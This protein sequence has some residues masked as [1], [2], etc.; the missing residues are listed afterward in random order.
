[1]RTKSSISTFVAL[2]LSVFVLSPSCQREV[3]QIETEVVHVEQG[4]SVLSFRLD[5]PG[6]DESTKSVITDPTF[7]SGIK[8]VL[9]L[10]VGSDG[11]WKKAYATT[12]DGLKQL[13]IRADG[14]TSYT[15]YAFANM[16]D[17]TIPTGAG[18][19]IRPDLF[20][21]TLPDSFSGLNST[22]LP[23]AGSIAVPAATV[24]P[25]GVTNI[26]VPLNRLLSK[27][28]V[29]IDK[30]GM[31]FG[32]SDGSALA[33]GSLKVCQVAKVVRP[34]AATANRRAQSSS[35]VYS[36]A[37][38]DYYDF[39]VT[40]R[41]NLVNENIV[42]YIAENRQ[43]NGSGSTQAGKTPATGRENLVTYLEYTA[44]KNGASDGVSGNMTY[45]VYLG[46]NV[47]NNFDVIGDK[48]YRATLNLSWLGMWEGPWRVTSS[49]WA[50]T[51]ALVI[52]KTANSAV[53]MGTGNTKAEAEKVRKTTP[54]AFYMNFFPNGTGASVSHGRKNLESWPYGWQI[55]VDGVALPSGTS[56]VIKNASNQDFIAWNY[57]A[58]DDCLSME[59][60]PG[61][62]SSPDIHTIQFKTL[63]GLKSSEVE[64]FVT[65][66]PFEYNWVDSGN[67][68]HVA[69]RGI[70][71]ARD[72]DTHIVDPQG[73]FHV[74]D[75]YSSKVRLTDNNDG[76]AKVELID[77]FTAIGDAIYIEDA[78]GDRH[79][80]VP[81]EARVP[82]WECTSLWTTYVDASV[83][84]KFMYLECDD[85]G[86]KSATAMVVTDN[87]SATSAITVGNKLDRG[88]VE[89][90]VGTSG[91]AR[92]A[93]GANSDNSK[94]GFTL[95]LNVSDG[96]Y[97]INTYIATYKGL[98]PSGNS[99]TVD[100]ANISIPNYS[101]RGTHSTNFIAWNPWKNIN[102][103]TEGDILNDYTLY[104]VPN[105]YM[106]SPTNGWM[107]S[108]PGY[109]PPSP[110]SNL[111]MDIQN[112]VVAH[113]GNVT[114]NALFDETT[115]YLGNICS[116]NPLKPMHKTSADFDPYTFSLIVDITNHD[117]YD[118]DKMYAYLYGRGYQ[119][120]DKVD[121]DAQLAE[122]NYSFVIGGSYSS[123]SAAW[124]DAPSGVTEST[125][126]YIQGTSFRVVSNSS[127]SEWGMIYGMEGKTKDDITTHGAGRINILMQ[128]HNIHDDSY[129][130]SLIGWAYMRLHVYI[131][132][133]VFPPT[134]Y[135]FSGSTSDPYASELATA[136]YAFSSL[137]WAPVDNCLLDFSGMDIVVPQDEIYNGVFIA[138]TSGL[139]PG[140][141]SKTI[142]STA[143]SGGRVTW[144]IIGHRTV[145]TAASLKEFLNST[146]DPYIYKSQGVIDPSYNYY[147]RYSGY[148]M[149]YDPSGTGKYSKGT[150]ADAKLYV[151]HL[152]DGPH[153]EVSNSHI[154][155]YNHAY[156]F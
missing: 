80:D 9:V 71:Q 82:Y 148:L 85:E 131:W 32:A 33:G 92:L 63:D 78:D 112:P 24:V 114:F 108:G 68:N 70:L 2:V 28:V 14:V 67:P 40:D 90:I 120:Y 147:Y 150:G 61:A 79:C 37:N 76:T 113:E 83:N 88:L 1:M 13:T 145:D 41:N 98:S 109:N 124:A 10:V 66:V 3:A 137:L 54:T 152:T 101:S 7:E 141:I 93:P 39:T 46:E 74:K 99:F 12:V 73:I 6:F 55:F 64:Y 116:I 117:N 72:A 47:T 118:K 25:N 51:R 87:G 15:V 103:V 57:N 143:G 44:A 107:T 77:G 60:V 38:S 102:K 53:P 31:L 156:G 122:Y 127:E 29:T 126:S 42:L 97:N 121:M 58:V 30:G 144:A 20:A 136:D 129:L 106:D 17:V 138:G 153:T 27:V 115:S 34:F 48:V 105:G 111:S 69:Q 123:S 133:V 18:G 50:D 151:L 11:H 95:S 142:P 22:G 65:S 35:E 16:G 86:G 43:G 56:G 8:S 100:R 135:H 110:G 154:Y 5:S 146:S 134:S 36:A 130:E 59:T 62:P 49:G 52:S 132:P 45:R 104:C 81:L 89:E 139:M 96:S 75:G 91:N 155:Y 4:E 21:Y 128:I 19:E 140:A 119:F 26:T 94:L 23:M 149:Y 125:S 84:L